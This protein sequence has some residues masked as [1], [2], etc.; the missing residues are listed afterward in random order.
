MMLEG[1]ESR[2]RKAKET[3]RDALGRA[4][5]GVSAGASTA[6]EFT[7]A[8]AAEAK[9][10]ANLVKRVVREAER[11]TALEQ[12]ASGSTERALDRAGSAV[13]GAAPAVGRGAEIAVDKVGA[14]LRYVSRPL[15]VV[16]GTIAGTLGGWWK[17]AAELR[18]DLPADEER[19]CRAH[20]ATLVVAPDMSF[21][22]ARGGYALGYVAGCNPE[23]RGRTFDDVE[24]DLRLGFAGEPAAEY[25]ALREFAR[26]GY[27][28]GALTRSG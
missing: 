11:D 21:D 17:R 7:K 15:A 18:S 2:L 19:E 20:F 26:F 28:R 16:V 22:Q 5:D 4:R 1:K 12:S 23:Y 10:K 27:S 24:T 6:A 25:D 14:A 13:S 9:E 8:V 3:T